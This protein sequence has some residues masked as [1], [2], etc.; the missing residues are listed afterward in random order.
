MSTP[1]EFSEASRAVA[2]AG[3]GY[4]LWGS[5]SLQLRGALRKP[6]RL[7]AHATMTATQLAQNG[8]T[9]PFKVTDHS[10]KIR[11]SCRSA[12]SAKM[13]AAS[14]QKDLVVTARLPTQE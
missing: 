10:M 1:P 14:M 2:A 11:S 13:A 4:L 3:S 12:I 7:N 6:T 5:A 8:I 9:T